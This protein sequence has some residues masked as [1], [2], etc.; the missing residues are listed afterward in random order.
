MRTGLFAAAS[1]ILLAGALAACSNG[2]SSTG[3]GQLAVNLVDAP[4]PAVDQI[5]VNVTK[6]TAHSSSGG[7]I[8]VGPLTSPTTVDLLKLQTSFAAL[9]LARL[10]AG[11]ITQ[12]R[13]YVA[14]DGDYVVPIGTTTPAPLVVP[15]GYE[16]GIKIIGPWDVPA[17]TRTTVTLDFD[18][19]NSIEY[20]QADGTW[21][22]RPVIRPKKTDAT[23]ISCDV[24]PGGQTCDAE[25]P[26]LEGQYCI[27][28]SCTSASLGS[29]G[30]TC[31]S[32]L[33]CLSGV[34]T[35]SNTC[36]PGQGGAPCVSGDG[37]MS[38]TC[39]PD[40]TCGPGS[41]SGAGS[42]CT[43]SDGCLSGNCGAG[44]CQPG[45][46]G[47]GCT[48]ATDCQSTPTQLSCVPGSGSGSGSCQPTIL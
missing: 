21:I 31:T 24:G 13:L 47:A 48:S 46:Q 37:C 25:N 11:K 40:G 43:S 32:G 35:S 41:A 9:G 23:A 30:S 39:Q 17:C 19:K 1:G 42:S 8:T 20:H 16:S 5:V 2:G 26:C 10:P 38:G 27:S 7:W 45:G 18:G 22:L 12:L 36:G 3:P 34:C 6:V 33:A 29:V 28:G 44:T 4:N 15:S 14:Q